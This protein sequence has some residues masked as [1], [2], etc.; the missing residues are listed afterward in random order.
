MTLAALIIKARMGFMD[1]ELV[2]QIK[3]NP[4]F[5]SSSAWKGF[6]SRRHLTHG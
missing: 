1:E 5:S 2:E 4:Y 6:K 3:E